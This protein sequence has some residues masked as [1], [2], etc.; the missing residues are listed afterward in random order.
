MAKAKGKIVSK[1]HLAR[2]ERE[3]RQ[4]RII[5]TVSAVVI[6]IVVLLVGYGLVKQFIVQP[7][8]AVA[9]VGDEVITTREFQV[10]ARYNRMQLV[11]QYN[12]IQQ[13]VQ[14]FGG[15]E[16]AASYF[17]QS[18]YQI[19]SQLNTPELLGQTV[20]DYL[21]EDILIRKEA[22]RL[23]ITVTD[24]EIDRS[25]Q[26]S[27]SYY[28]NGTPTPE[29]TLPVIPT[30]T[31]SP[32]QLALVPPTVEPTAESTAEATAVPT[33]T[34][35]AAAEPTL[36]PTPYTEKLFEDNYNSYLGNFRD[37]ARISEKDFRWI[38]EMEL[39]RQKV[40]DVV[41]ADVKRTS[42]QVWARHILVADEA[43][44]QSVLTRLAAGE[45]FAALA[46]ELSTDT[47]SAPMGGDLG[48]FS[49][50]AMVAEFNAAAF[51]L[52]V[53]EVSQPV[54]TTYGYHIIQ[55]LGHEERA[56]ADTDY[57]NAQQTAFGN[58][59]TELRVANDI[60]TYD[61]IWLDRVPTQPALQ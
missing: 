6:A 45:D 26:E 38:V 51:S 50:G 13:Y 9:K 60:E 43:T 42:E 54:Q 25:I 21:I 11:S 35:E 46:A 1:K 7:G 29:P 17:Q 44:A 16:S 36:E 33:A 47:G 18:I 14:M 20:L 32:T 30:S 8:Q 10:F 39:Y 56:M 31:L 19:Q 58:W 41:T 12:Q 53:G 40:F 4:N 48:W 37:L 22:E 59:L 49:S 3:R 5:L 27:F 34:A 24:E 28:A 2:V 23:G 61:E 52:A 57:Q 15:D 55:V